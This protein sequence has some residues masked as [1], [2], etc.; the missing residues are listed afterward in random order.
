MR[1]IVAV[2]IGGTHA[3]FALATIDQRRV[4]SLGPEAVF[5]TAEFGS[6]VSAWQA[7]AG[8]LGRT[9]PDA[10]AIAIASPVEGTF[11]KLT[12]CPWV[13]RRDSIAADLG[14]VEVSLIND[15]GAVAHSVAALDETHFH[16]L[17]GPQ[18]PLPALG[19]I[20]VVGP[21]T[22]LGVAQLLLRG[23]G[24]YEVVESEGGHI[25]FAP[26]DSIDDAILLGLRKRFGRVS[27]ERLSSGP[28]LVNIYEMLARLEGR[29]AVTLDQVELWAAAM[30]GDDLQSRLALERFCLCLGAIAGDIALVHG[31]DALVIGGGVGL[32]LA[33]LLPQSGFE[34]RFTA[35]GRF[36]P[37]MANIPVKIITYPQPGLL[38]ASAAFARGD[39]AGSSPAL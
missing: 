17:C 23:D 10:A 32:R 9:L 25:D 35:K 15:F 37:R 19:S 11:L 1:E 20:S 18:A 24:N 26:I 28:G 31:A 5:K 36:A 7:F 21:G 13:I 30:G 33:D 4:V 12:N 8:S 29:D 3:R 14:L 27:V 22:G 38:G 39:R 2:D 6:L 16:H 34:A